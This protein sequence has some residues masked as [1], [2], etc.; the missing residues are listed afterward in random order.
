M[1]QQA[2]NPDNLS[3]NAAF[4]MKAGHFTLPALL[5]RADDGAA[6]D[7]FL[8]EQIAKLPQFFDQAPLVLDLSQYP[9]D[10]PFENFPGL[11]G[12]VRG[13]GMIPIGVR[14][15]SEALEQQARMLELAV[16]P[17][18]RVQRER[19]SSPV[20]APT[21][22]ETQPAAPRNTLVIEQP[23]RSGQRIYAEGADLVLLAGVSSGAEVIADGCVHAYGA[24][25]GRVLAGVRENPQARIFCR[26]LGAELIAI[27]GRYR[28]AE[29]MP[30]KF[31]GRSVQVS[32]NENS[33][34]FAYL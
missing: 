21:P 13:H 2:A 6:L 20:A 18:Q 19:Q 3:S 27:A 29:D 28:V 17:R 5:I 33:L 9:K 26:D 31:I 10:V 25:R 24:V 7:S 12:M 30:R 32:L 22:A 1:T 15:A 23:V 8:A 11:I 14:G 4:D 34:Q 16:M